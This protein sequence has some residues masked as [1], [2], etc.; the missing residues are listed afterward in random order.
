MA[1]CFYPLS[2]HYDGKHFYNPNRK[3]PHRTFK[4]MF[5]LLKAFSR[6]KKWLKRKSAIKQPSLANSLSLKQTYITYINHSCHLIQLKGLN[7]LTDPIFSK[8][9]GPFSLLGP[10]RHA[11]PGI[12]LHQLPHIHVVLV[13]HNHYDHMDLP[14]LKKLEHLYHPLFIV[15]LGNK[16][17]L[18]KFSRV[19][20]LDWWQTHKINEQQYITM[21]PAQHW[22][23]RRIGDANK[24]LWA[25]YWISSG[26][27]KIYFIGDSGY[28]P[29]FKAIAEKMG[30]P[31]ISFLPIGSYEPRW[32]M[33]NHHMN[34]N[35]AVQASLD[36][37]SEHN[38][39]NH[40]HTFKL[41]TEDREDPVEE[42]KNS[43]KKHNLDE[44]RF[45][46]P[47]NGETIIFEINIPK[48][49]D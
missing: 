8:R 22:S 11:A 9:A 14:S 34:P 4:T 1:K 13:S 46:T 12:K 36:L 20:E 5:K 48:K 25:G 23:M 29:H 40:Y 16:K 15:P 17:Y 39:A 18:K 32:F 30:A 41:S 49:L 35:E 38:I 26:E 2:D 27:I 37:H 21:V 7:I 19:L 33:V 31:T 28:G 43:L 10:K 6:S 42:L 3:G 44:Q 24:A 47:I 45:F